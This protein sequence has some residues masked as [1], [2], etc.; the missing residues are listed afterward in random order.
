[1]LG[2]AEHAERRHVQDLRVAALEQPGAVCPGHEPHLGGQRTDLVGLAAVEPD[3]LLDHALAHDFLLDL[4]ER[5][6]DRA[7]HL[8]PLLLAVALLQRLLEVLLQRVERGIALRPVGDERGRE[9]VPRELVDV[10]PDVLRVQ[11]RRLERPLLD[12]QL[13]QEVVLESMIW[14]MASLATSRPSATSSSVG[15]CAPSSSMSLQASSVASPSIIR[16][17]TPPWS[18]L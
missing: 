5:R 8:G 13:A 14:P 17:S 15:G 16:M 9:P 7:L 11:R 4:L 18:L 10:V 2:H 12:A 6:T 3:A 1:L